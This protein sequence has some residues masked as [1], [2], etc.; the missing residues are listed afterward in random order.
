MLVQCELIYA[1]AYTDTRL[2]LVEKKIL[3]Y[4]Y[5]EKGV[6]DTCLLLY[7]FFIL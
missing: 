4:E 1:W 3:Y 2:A 6:F 5:A 7:A